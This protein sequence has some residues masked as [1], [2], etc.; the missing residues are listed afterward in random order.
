VDFVGIVV[1]SKDKK[2][3]MLTELMDGSLEKFVKY[4]TPG[5]KLQASLAVTRGM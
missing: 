2:I 5:Q 3:W 1:T 4:I